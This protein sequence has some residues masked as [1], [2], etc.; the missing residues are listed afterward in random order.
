M[1]SRRVSNFLL[2]AVAAALGFATL[3][4]AGAF[5]EPEPDRLRI[6]FGRLSFF[7]V[8]L[9]C[10]AV[11]DLGCGSL[12][13]PLMTQIERHPN[14]SRVWINRSGTVL[15]VQRAERADSRGPTTAVE[16]AFRGRGMDAA[17]LDGDALGD[18][19]HNFV[20]RDAVWYR[21]ADVDRLSETEAQVVATRIVGRVERRI[22][23]PPES[24]RAFRKELS[25]AFALCFRKGC[26]A[27]RRE[28]DR[29]AAKYLDARGVAVFDRSLEQGLE[30]LPGEK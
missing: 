11:K 18:A 17:P 15:A 29:V 19:R 12:A 25:T 13:G 8:P 22:A 10:P 1:N 7:A 20:L 30:A 28:I 2:F 6:P 5:P 26:S 16:A 9:G 4:T 14:V 23:L 24:A 3:R 27:G 21:P